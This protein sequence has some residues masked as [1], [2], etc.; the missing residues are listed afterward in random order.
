MKKFKALLTG[1][2]TATLLSVTATGSMTANAEGAKG[3]ITITG[4]T[5]GETY[6][7][8]EV[9][10]YTAVDES[11]NADGQFADTQGT[12]KVTTEWVEF[13]TSDEYNLSSFITKYDNDYYVT[14]VNESNATAL[15]FAIQTGSIKYIASH[16]N[17]TVAKTVT[18]KEGT[19]T[20]TDLPYGYYVIDSSLGA[21][22]STGLTSPSVSVAEKNSTTPAPEK[23]VQENSKASETFSI[24]ESNGWGEWNDGQI[25]DTVTFKTKVTILPKTTNVV[26]HDTMDASLKYNADVVV[27]YAEDAAGNNVTDAVKN[28][29]VCAPEGN[30]FTVSFDA[31]YTEALT[32]NVYVTVVYTANITEDAGVNVGHMNETYVSFGNGGK[33]SYS[34]TYTYTYDLNIVKQDG[35]GQALNDTHFS[36]LAGDHETVLKVVKNSE[37]VYTLAADQN[38]DNVTEDIV[39]SE[40]GRIQIKGLDT[41]VYYLRE[42]QAKAGYNMLTDDIKIFIA[43][44]VTDET[45]HAAIGTLTATYGEDD[46][47]V[48]GKVS[49]NNNVL[50]VINTTGAYL[51][52][53]GGV[54]TTMFYLVGGVLILSAVAAFIVKRKTAA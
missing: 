52:S 2:L 49:V 34:R 47:A 53:T 4:T 39:T 23:K 48:I 27:Y 41:G 37:G 35:N 19:T 9:L 45:S 7:A 11:L 1:I 10:E 28:I 32:D 14:G 31:K 33:T 42:T 43:G 24:D 26:L 3:S 18:A 17:L 44:T 16:Q 22:N 29:A 13:F 8:Y 40:E 46:A 20:I 15:K 12:Y 38:A 51:P 5:A 6:T 30:G 25:G 50:Y 36:L 21:I 54:G